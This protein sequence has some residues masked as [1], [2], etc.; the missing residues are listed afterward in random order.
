[1]QTIETMEKNRRTIEQ[2]SE[3]TEALFNEVGQLP[4]SDCAKTSMVMIMLG[5]ITR[6][7][8][9]QVTFDISAKP[10]KPQQAR[11]QP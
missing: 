1:M 3:L 7:K 11:A 5:D 2:L 8:G 6:R 10:E 4:I 9:N